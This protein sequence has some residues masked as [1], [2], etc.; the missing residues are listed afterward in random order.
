[1]TVH[2]QLHIH[3]HTVSF[4]HS[5][6]LRGLAATGGEKCAGRGVLTFHNITVNALLCRGAGES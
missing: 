2:T 5:A 6:E 4:D 3:G 1:M